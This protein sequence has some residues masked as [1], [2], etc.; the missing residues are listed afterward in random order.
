MMVVSLVI[1]RSFLEILVVSGRFNES[2]MIRSVNQESGKL[3]WE[4]NLDKKYSS[5]VVVELIF[6]EKF[7]HFIVMV[8]G[9]DALWDI[10][11]TSLDG[12]VLWRRGKFD[13][14]SILN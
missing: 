14:I 10:F 13:L 6:N 3:L 12:S 11:C 8:K 4:A 2:V 7:N 9:D 5:D 1:A